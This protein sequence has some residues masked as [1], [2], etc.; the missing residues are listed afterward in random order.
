MSHYLKLGSSREKLEQRKIELEQ[1]LLEAK[2]EQIGNMAKTEE[3][4]ERAI[5]AM[6]SYQ[7]FEQEIPDAFDGDFE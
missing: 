1:K 5:R 2:A 6:K 7:G 4:L 3:L